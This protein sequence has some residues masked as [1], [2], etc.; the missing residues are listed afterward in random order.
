MAEVELK[1]G[2]ADKAEKRVR[3]IVAKNPK[4]AV[5]YTLLGE[6]ASA[7]KQ[8]AAAL[9]AYRKAHQ[10]EPST[11]TLLRLLIAHEK[12]GVGG[13]ALKLAED[14]LKAYPKDLTVIRALGDAYARA[15]NFAAAR[16]S[17]EQALKV[18]PNDGAVLNNLANVLFRLKSP[19]A[20]RVAEQAVANSPGNPLV[21]DTFA[22]GLFQTGETERSL[23]LLREARL[24]A[25]DSAEIRYHLGVV[26][27][28]AGKRDEAIDELNASVSSGQ[29]FD[30]LERARELLKS[31]RQR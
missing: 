22:W 17:Y 20:L 29:I 2:A 24:R 1:M 7:R 28:K 6:I 21:L 13:A 11:D 4:L 25:P 30:D 10:V 27:A 16:R 31:M 26:L 15:G 9:E 19:D 5:G 12:V 8:P 3:D 18:M 14:W 23:Q